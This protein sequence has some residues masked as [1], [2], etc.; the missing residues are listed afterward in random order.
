M[1]QFLLFLLHINM[2]KVTRHFRAIP[3]LTCLFDKFYWVQ[4][5]DSTAPPLHEVPLRPR[6]TNNHEVPYIVGG[7]CFFGRSDA[8]LH[9]SDA[10]GQLHFTAESAPRG[11]CLAVGRPPSTRLWHNPRRYVLF[12]VHTATVH[13]F[14]RR[15]LCESDDQRDPLPRTFFIGSRRNASKRLP[16]GMIRFAFFHF[17]RS[18]SGTDRSLS[19][20]RSPGCLGN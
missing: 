7:Y 6:E 3:S 18:A 20:R 17:I 19:R 16:N 2:T 9:A 11:W 15:L 14:P 8:S 4:L 5:T 12:V 13:V 10:T 1:L